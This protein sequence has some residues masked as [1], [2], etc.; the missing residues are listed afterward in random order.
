MAIEGYVLGFDFG[1]KFI[2]LAVGQT[3]TKTAGGLKTLKARKGKPN[4]AEITSILQ[5]YKPAAIVVGLPLNMDESESDMSARARKFAQEIERR[6]GIAVQ[7]M[8]ERLS[9]WTANEVTRDTV[10]GGEIH[11]KSACLILESWFNE[12]D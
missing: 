7:M 3:V 1:L 12:L 8:D 4:W 9:S 10:R 2:G 6:S 5:E 11:E